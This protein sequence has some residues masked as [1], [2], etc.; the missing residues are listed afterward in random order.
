[1][2][3]QQLPRTKSGFGHPQGSGGPQWQWLSGVF[4]GVMLSA[5][6][7]PQERHKQALQTGSALFAHFC[8]SRH[9]ADARGNGVVAPYLAA[10]VPDLSLVAARRGCRFSD[11]EIGDGEPL[12][13]L[14]LPQLC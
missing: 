12:A 1:M 3:E 4:L 8:E 9:G 10:K 5:C 7:D 11:D 6:A 13:G 2:H 14:N